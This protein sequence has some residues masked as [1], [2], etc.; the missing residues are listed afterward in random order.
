MHLADSSN[1]LRGPHVFALRKITPTTPWSHHEHQ[2]NEL[3]SDRSIVT[4]PQSRN[5]CLLSLF[6][7]HVF[8]QAM[9]LDPRQ[10][11]N[12]VCFFFSV[13]FT[14][15]TWLSSLWFNFFAS[16]LCRQFL[17]SRSSLWPLFTSMLLFH[18]SLF[19]E[20]YFP[21]ELVDVYWVLD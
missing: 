17:I 8:Y 9:D 3:Q 10:Y 12:V 20:S 7:S 11:E 1:D 6:P 4:A 15:S 16:L 14:V 21:V 19:L 2:R 5:W 13:C 18:F